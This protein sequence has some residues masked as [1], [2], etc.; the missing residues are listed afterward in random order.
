MSEGRK[1]A[2]PTDLGTRGRRFWRETLGHWDLTKPELELL[3]EACR[4]M[5]RI[6]MYRALVDEQGLMVPG[7]MGQ[8]VMHPALAQERAEVGLVSKLLGQLA[9]PDEDGAAVATPLQARARK[10]AQSRWARDPYREARQ[11]RRDQR[12]Q[13]S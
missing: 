1:P 11:N 7:S 10:A 13:A 4:R 6:D 9:L 5:D 12:G 2:V 3:A 8:M